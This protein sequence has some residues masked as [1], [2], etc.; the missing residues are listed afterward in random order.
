MSRFKWTHLTHNNVFKIWR[1]AKCEV[2]GAMFVCCLF[3]T[4]L[5]GTAR[6]EKPALQGVA[7]RR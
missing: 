2:R 4:L 6:E 7:P 3:V 5:A 1:A